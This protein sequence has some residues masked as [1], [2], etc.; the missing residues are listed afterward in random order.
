MWQVATW[1]AKKA[2]KLAI[3]EF[4]KDPELQNM[5]VE[6]GKKHLENFLNKRKLKK[7]KQKEFR[8]FYLACLL[9]VALADD[10]TKEEESVLKNMFGEMFE[11]LKTKTQEELL[12]IVKHYVKDNRMPLEDRK[13]IVLSCIDMAIADMDFDQKEEN[14]IK[15]LAEVLEIEENWTSKQLKATKRL[16][17]CLSDDFLKDYEN[18]ENFTFFFKIKPKDYQKLQKE[19][20]PKGKNFIS[21]FCIYR[22][23]GLIKTENIALV[24]FK[25]LYGKW[26]NAE[27]EFLPFADIEKIS[28][29]KNEEEEKLT[30]HSIKHKKYTIEAQDL[31]PFFEF[32]SK[33]FGEIIE[34]NSFTGG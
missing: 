10:L 22:T 26:K 6:Q 9:S 11:E 14:L 17:S 32:L 5:L 20:C 2:V 29:S 7:E 4:Q 13:D 30:F 27:K 16:I 25:G 23:K 12:D 28:F 19:F 18:S 1:L 8:K 15:G 21:V 31:E 34:T 24:T 33:Q 3:N